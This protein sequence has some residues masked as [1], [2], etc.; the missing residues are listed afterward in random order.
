MQGS[1]YEIKAESSECQ[2]S[3][4]TERNMEGTCSTIP[5]LGVVL[6]APPALKVAC[7][8]NFT[9][10]SPISKTNGFFGALVFLCSP[11]LTRD[12]P[13]GGPFEPD[14]GPAHLY[15]RLAFPKKRRYPRRSRPV[16]PGDSAGARLKSA[17]ERGDVV[18]PAHETR[19]IF[20]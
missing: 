18:K 4:R 9:C 20:F 16:S 5:R 15:S 3:S 8:I 2:E 1:D 12:P 17:L 14:P 6:P 19:G 7:T 10:F 11:G 13:P